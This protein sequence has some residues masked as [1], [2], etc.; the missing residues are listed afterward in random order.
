M[1]KPESCIICTL[2]APVLRKKASLIT[3]FGA[4]LEKKAEQMLQSMYTANGIGLAAPQIGDPIQLV[5]IDLELEKSDTSVIL[6][7]RTLPLQLLQPFCFINPTFEPVNDVKLSKEEGCLSLP[8]VRGNVSRFHEIKLHY[9][10][11]WGA[12]HVLQ[13]RDLFARCIQHECDHL[14]GI[15]FIDHL[16]KTE[17]KDNQALLEDIKA[18]GGQFDYALLEND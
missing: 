13:C 10:D 15:L 18:L 11:L 5:V 2:G 17:R 8:D 16:S 3:E 12:Q 7:G 14:R 9:Q 6:D 1:T 4:Q